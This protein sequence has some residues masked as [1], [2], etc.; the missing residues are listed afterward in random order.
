M[1]PI[2]R[3]SVVLAD[4]CN[5]FEVNGL[6]SWAPEDFYFAA[7]K[8]VGHMKMIR[9]IGDTLGIND[10]VQAFNDMMYHLEWD[11]PDEHKGHMLAACLNELYDEYM[12]EA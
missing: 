3:V 11:L 6:T 12:G 8:F 9:E 10:K 7:R 4:Q 2:D 1:T 5:G